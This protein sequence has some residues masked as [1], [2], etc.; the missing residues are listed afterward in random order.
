MATR[1]KV[2]LLYNETNPELYIYKS[3]LEKSNLNFKP[4]F[5]IENVTPMDEY[6]QMGQRIASQGYEVKS[7]NVNDNLDVLLNA[8]QE[9]KPDV[10]FNFVEI[11]HGQPKLE[12]NVAG[13]FDLYGVPYT[14]APPIAL[15]TCQNKLLAKKIL[16]A[17]GI[18]TPAF[19]IFPVVR[20]LKV[21]H[22]LNYPLI[23]KPLFEDASVGIENASVVHDMKSLRKRIKHVHTEFK[24]PALVEEFIEGREL[25]VSVL[26]DKETA[27]L[28]ISEIDFSTMPDHL[29]NIVSYQAKWDSLHEAYHKTIPICPAKLPKK[30]LAKIE[31]IALKAFSVLHLRDYA[32]V[33]MRL[34]ADGEVFVLEAN[35]NPDLSEGAGFMRS[36]EAAGYPYEKALDKLIQL[37]LERGKK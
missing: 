6:D 31:K 25:N 30:L 34:R 10:V 17:N 21:K 28:P 1:S 9:Y 33:D 14:G 11:F 32:R 7:L 35:P 29:E 3:E 23:V 20:T 13:L 27:V 22:N 8:L 12:M 24:Q 26:G 15:A 2:L 19:E 36:A 37:A 16:I 18:Q 4:Y 5:E